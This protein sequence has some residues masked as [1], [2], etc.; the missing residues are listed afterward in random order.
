MIANY[1][2]HT[3][4]CG[5]AR[6]E[7]RAYV[8]AAI[9][10]GLKIMGF[11]DHVTMPFP[12]GHDSYFRIPR[13]R[14]EDYVESVLSLRKEFASDIRILLGFEAEY[15][16]DL[17]EPLMELLAPY[18]VDY[19]LLGQHY[20]GS[21]EQDQN[22]KP[23][24]SEARLVTYVDRI[25]AGLATGRFSYVCHPD[26]IHFTGDSAIYEREMSR[27]IRGVKAMDLPLE[28][29]LLGIREKRNY[30]NPAFWELV[31]G[32]GIKTIIGCDAHDPEDMAAP[33]Q[34]QAARDFAA[35]FDLK[36]E[37]I[38]PIKNPKT[39]ESIWVESL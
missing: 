10:R 19:L 16:P 7:D 11:S 21:E 24:D 17:F 31:R 4:R 35:R 38:I 23:S 9:A 26:L 29:N 8:E 6:G 20:N 37:T 12:D 22:Q 13:A 33:G 2:T 1:H 28:I 3:A 5:H 34:L 36:P 27:L 39:G 30:P 18:P 32:S 15:Y 25:L 14:L